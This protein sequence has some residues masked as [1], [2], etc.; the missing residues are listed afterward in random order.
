MTN[1]K[2]PPQKNS[3]MDTSEPKAVST[4][5]TKKRQADETS[6]TEQKKWP[7]THPLTPDN[8]PV[9]IKAVIKALP[10]SS[11]T[12]TGKE[13]A[14]AITEERTNEQCNEEKCKMTRTRTVTLRSLVNLK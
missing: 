7:K 5:S 6:S 4:H 14:T 12:T 13:A 1:V 8:V 11:S 2:T 10:E 3:V 9:I